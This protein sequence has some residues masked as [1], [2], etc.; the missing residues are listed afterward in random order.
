[1]QVTRVLVDSSISKK[2]NWS[3]VQACL[4]VIKTKKKLND[5]LKNA[6]LLVINLLK[7]K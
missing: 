7:T 2:M 1:M 3:V 6:D 5:L 4:P